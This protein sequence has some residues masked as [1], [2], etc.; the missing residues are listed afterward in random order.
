MNSPS[1]PQ[2]FEGFGAILW[3]C[4]TF[5]VVFIIAALAF[6]FGGGR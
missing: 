6:A 2:R 1:D 3:G 4:G 5:L